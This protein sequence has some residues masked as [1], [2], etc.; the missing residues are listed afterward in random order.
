MRSVP[1]AYRAGADRT[2]SSQRRSISNFDPAR[3]DGRGMPLS[4]ILGRW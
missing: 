4:I 3:T 1:P 2:I